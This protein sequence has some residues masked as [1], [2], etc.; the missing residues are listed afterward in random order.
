M[1]SCS[2]SET[3]VKLSLLSS[4]SLLWGTIYQNTPL[5]QFY[6]K[7]CISDNHIETESLLLSNYAVSSK[8]AKN[9]ILQT[10]SEKC[11]CNFVMTALLLIYN[12]RSDHLERL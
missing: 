6:I 8:R 1:Q 9:V 4:H 11:L 2:R 12:V 10:I 5:V 7:I 3:F